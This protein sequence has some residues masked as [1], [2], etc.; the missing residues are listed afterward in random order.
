MLRDEL[1]IRTYQQK[2]SNKT[3]SRSKRSWNW[4][5]SAFHWAFGLMDADTAATYDSKINELINE[6]SRIHNDIGDETIF[7]KEFIKLNNNTQT[8]L[9]MQFTKINKKLN[10][11]IKL[12]GDKMRAQ[13]EKTEFNHVI[14]ET[15]TIL[16]LR[17]ME[18]QR[19]SNQILSSL[20]NTA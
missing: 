1:D 13:I 9:S 5:G 4:A 14:Q 19:L 12:S 20:K 11:Y 16:L 3:H 2:L 8:E 17:I 15:I 7:I 6:T 10:N 18:H